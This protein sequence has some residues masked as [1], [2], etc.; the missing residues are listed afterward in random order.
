MPRVFEVPVVAADGHRT[1]LQ[2]RAPDTPRATLLWL[3]GMGIAARHFLAF[4]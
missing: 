2:A 3:P 1:I 4:A